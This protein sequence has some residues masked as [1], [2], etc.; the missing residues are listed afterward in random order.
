MAVT[1]EPSRGSLR[2]D[3]G[4][5]EMKYT[6]TN[7]DAVADADSLVELAIAASELQGLEPMD[8]LFDCEFHLFYSK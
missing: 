6:V 5:D 4:S 1:T 8:L 3:Y 7:L 2:I